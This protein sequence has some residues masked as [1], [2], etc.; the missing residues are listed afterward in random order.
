MDLKKTATYALQVEEYTDDQ[1]YG[2]DEGGYDEQ[3]FDSSLMAQD[4]GMSPSG[5]DTFIF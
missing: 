2:Y 1:A 4:V 5:T 3:D